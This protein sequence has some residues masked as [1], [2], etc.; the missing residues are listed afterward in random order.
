M[1]LLAIPVPMLLTLGWLIAIA[2]VIYLAAKG[3][4]NWLSRRRQE[5]KIHRQADLNKL[6]VVLPMIAAF[7]LLMGF[8]VT[9]LRYIM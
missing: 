7:G 8:L 2:F 5:K 4:K 9:V 3:L 1:L 6:V